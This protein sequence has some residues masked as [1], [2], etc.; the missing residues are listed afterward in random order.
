MTLTEKLLEDI[1]D[2]IQLL[3]FC[4][5]CIASNLGKWE[6][7]W[8]AAAFIGIILYFDTRKNAHKKLAKEQA[9][10]IEALGQ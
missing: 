8:Q 3:V 10:R 1:Y 4:I 6:W 5:V 2:G 7:W 9:E